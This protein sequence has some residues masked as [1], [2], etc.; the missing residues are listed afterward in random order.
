MVPYISI[1]FT[2]HQI[3]ITYH[4]PVNGFGGT[5]MEAKVNESSEWS[6][7]WCP[8]MTG[9]YHTIWVKIMSLLPFSVECFL[10]NFRYYL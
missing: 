3:V 7:R 5:R 8:S 10:E 1:I 4:V 9:R 2:V 6:F